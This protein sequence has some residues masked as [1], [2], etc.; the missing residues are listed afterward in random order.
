[1]TTVPEL[2]REDDDSRLRRAPRL[3]RRPPARIRESPELRAGFL[4]TVAISLGVVVANLTTPVPIQLVLDHGF[5][6]GFRPVYVSSS[7]RRRSGSSC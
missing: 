2:L 4:L 5:D 7:A 1:M 3:V 6:G